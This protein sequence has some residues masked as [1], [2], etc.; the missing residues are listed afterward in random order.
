M[1]KVQKYNSFSAEVAEFA[2]W[3][4]FNWYWRNVSL[5]I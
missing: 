3:Q 4:N 2:L 1:D 5:F